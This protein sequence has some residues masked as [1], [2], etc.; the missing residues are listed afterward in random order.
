MSKGSVRRPENT[1]KFE[2]NFNKIFGKHEKPKKEKQ[3]N[4]KD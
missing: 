3:E 2:E 4:E 1:D